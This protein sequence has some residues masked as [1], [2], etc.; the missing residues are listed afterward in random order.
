MGS[1][2]KENLG[3]GVRRMKSLA[4]LLLLAVCWPVVIDAACPGAGDRLQSHGTMGRVAGWEGG[5]EPVRIESG[6]SYNVIIP[7]EPGY[8]SPQLGM[9][10]MCCL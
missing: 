10:T 9:S 6:C 5:N 3:V 2:A 8:M 1:G 7:G 4:V